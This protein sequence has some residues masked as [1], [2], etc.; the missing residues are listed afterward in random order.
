MARLK[1]A[2]MLVLLDSVYLLSCVCMLIVLFD[3]C[4]VRL[5]GFCC[6]LQFASTRLHGVEEVVAISGD[7]SVVHCQGL[8]WAGLRGF[9]DVRPSAFIVT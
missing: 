8:S 3:A 9:A 1:Q 5:A 7:V 2:T 6:I 4:A